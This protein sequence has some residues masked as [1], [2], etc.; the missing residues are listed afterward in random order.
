MNLQE[1]GW[2]GTDW[3]GLTQDRDWWWV[4]VN[5]VMKALIP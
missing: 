4:L 2:G 1:V 5:V 3:I